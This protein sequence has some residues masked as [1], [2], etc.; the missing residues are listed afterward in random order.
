[1]TLPDTG[2]GAPQRRY[3]RGFRWLG[4]LGVAL[5]TVTALPTG[6]ARLGIHTSDV[7][8]LGWFGRHPMI[9]LTCALV[10]MGVLLVAWLWLGRL[11]RSSNAEDV[12]PGWLRRTLAAWIAPLLIS[13]A[14]FSGDVY[15]YLAQ[16]AMADDGLDPYPPGGPAQAFGEDSPLTENVSGYWRHIPAP[17]G[18]VFGTI[19]RVIMAVSGEHTWLAVA[20]HRI[21]AIAGVALIVWAVPRLARRAGVSRSGALWLGVL[22]PL[23]LWHL[24]GGVHNDALMVGLMLVGV[25]F[26][27]AAL[28]T[29]RHPPLS[30]FAGGVALIGIAAGVKL[31][32]ALALTVPAAMLARR[33]GAKLA[34]LL[35]AGLTVLVAGAAILVAV[36]VGSGFGFGWFDALDT[37]GQVN[38]WMAP[39]NQVGFLV[40][41]VASL[42][43]LHITQAAI[44]VSKLGGVFVGAMAGATI[45]WHMLRSWISP[46]LG[47]GLLFAVAIVCGPV[48]QPWY[49]LWAVVALAAS[50]PSGR[51]RLALTTVV[52]VFALVLPPTGGNF[53]DRIPELLGAYAIAGVLVAGLFVLGQR[54]LFP[55]VCRRYT[56]RRSEAQ[57]ESS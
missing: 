1:M 50:L 4:V 48:V 16:G 45:V 19:E 17:Y 11:V 6:A 36:S 7:V 3:L 57:R 52:T 22:N 15:I 55:R 33:W 44:A 5:L 43:G 10:G 30:A 49:L 38:S 23:V 35:G 28:S 34:H 31:T 24:V 26:T 27:L 37:P 42:F 21:V 47:L 9:A 53:A 54:G 25:E 56:S 20:L 29:P 18:P 40:G 8:L 14:L 46:V 51:A 12:S 32:A 2:R 39:T 41:G 13:P